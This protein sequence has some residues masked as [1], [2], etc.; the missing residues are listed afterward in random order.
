MFS[1]VNYC[2]S[3]NYPPPPRKVIG[4]SNGGGVLKNR[5]FLKGHDHEDHEDFADFLSKLC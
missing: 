3:R 5:T 1:K 2:G 4:N